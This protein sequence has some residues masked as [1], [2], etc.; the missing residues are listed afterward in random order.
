MP[1]SGNFEELLLSD[2]GLTVSGSSSGMEN[3]TLMSRHVAVH[4]N[5]HIAKGETNDDPEKWMTDDPLDAPGFEGGQALALGW[6]TLFVENTND[7]PS[8]VT[9]TWSEQVTIAGTRE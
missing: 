8:F 6:E 9:F 1:V 2:D 3:A 7:L 4:Q 5:G